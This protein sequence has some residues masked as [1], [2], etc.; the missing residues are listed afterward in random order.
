MWNT[1]IHKAFRAFWLFIS[2]KNTPLFILKKMSNL[3]F[4]PKYS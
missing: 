2:S 1:R 3:A 4:I